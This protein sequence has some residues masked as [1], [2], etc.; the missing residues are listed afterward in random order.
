MDQTL[1]ELKPLEE[2]IGTHFLYCWYGS[3]FLDT[4]P[5]I[6]VT[7][8]NYTHTHTHTHTYIYIFSSD[9]VKHLYVCICVCVYIYIY[10]YVYSLVYII[11]LLCKKSII[12]RVKESP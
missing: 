8:E 6:Q 7:E 2:N 11:K 5:E 1:E 9:L 4:G 12:N 10:I 3:G